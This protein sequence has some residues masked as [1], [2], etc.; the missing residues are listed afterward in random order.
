MVDHELRMAVCMGEGTFLREKVVLTVLG[1][2]DD[3]IG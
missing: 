1:N 3:L 2:R